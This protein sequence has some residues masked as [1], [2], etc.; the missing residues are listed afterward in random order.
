[1]YFVNKF[2]FTEHMTKGW[3]IEYVRTPATQLLSFEVGKT[4]PCP[5]SSLRG[6]ELPSI[7]SSALVFQYGSIMK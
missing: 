4:P 7:T 5:L 2:M 6:R 3:E 1:M